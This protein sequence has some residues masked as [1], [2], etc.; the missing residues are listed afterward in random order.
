MPTIETA[1]SWY[2]ENDPVHGFDHILRVYKM[3]ERLAQSEGADIEIVR[4]AAL[5][6]DVDSSQLSE[7][8]SQRKSHHHTAAGFAHILLGS[9]GWSED[10]IEAVAH[11]I[12][13]H[14]FR[15]DREQP[16]TL[17]A[18]VLFDAD[19]LDAIGA[20]GAVRAIAYAVLAK[21]QLHAKPSEQFLQIGEK[22]TGEPHTPYHEHLFKLSKLKERMLT[23][24]GRL[25]AEQRHQFLE[26]FFAQ[27][28]AELRAER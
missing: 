13:A 14:R 11:C 1:K 17:E 9:E 26:N 15:D 16:Q 23:S 2:P 18:K 3:A 20:I 24:S 27:W 10:R 12:R 6:H 4:A 28:Q 22:E 5:L 7:V 19:K 25:I 8:S 21:Q